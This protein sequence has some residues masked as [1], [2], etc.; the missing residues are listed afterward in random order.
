[1]TD[2]NKIFKIPVEKSIQYSDNRK[3]MEQT[4]DYAVKKVLNT[5]EGTIEKVPINY[6]DIVNKAYVDA[7]TGT[8]SAGSTAFVELTDTPSGY[9]TADY[10]VRTNGVDGLYYGTASS[11]GAGVSVHSDLTN[12][13]YASAGHTGFAATADIPVVTIDFDAVGTDNSDNNAVNTLYSGLISYTGTASDAVALN[14]AKVSF[15][16]DYDYG[17][18]INNP[19][20]ISGA[21]A[22]AITANSAKISYTGTAS[23]AVALNT[24]KVSY[25]GTASNAVAANTAKL[26]YTGF[27]GDHGTATT[28]E[29]VNVC[30]GTSATPPTASTTTEGT[31]YIQ[32]TA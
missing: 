14:T 28:D 1:M 20:T 6:N 30:Y 18:L 25:T 22:S 15:D 4:E 29:I 23:S 2:I 21:Q 19:T 17:D 5:Q 13:S 24:A 7:H 16:W 10:Y 31:I 27:A 11:G 12:L 26:S 32:Y 8:V 9:G 3:S